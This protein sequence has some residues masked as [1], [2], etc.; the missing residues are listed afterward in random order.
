VVKNVHGG[1]IYT[2]GILKGKALLDFSSNINPLGVPESFRKNIN[3]A[4]N[5][6]DK[7]PDI[8]YR[9][10]I[11][12]LKEYTGKSDS[13]FLLGNG[14]A[15]LLDVS[16]SLTKKLL[17]VVPSFI[18][19]EESAKK[20]GCEI[21]Y[22]YLLPDFTIDYKDI[23]S[24]LEKCDGLVIANPNNPNGACINI[25]E[26]LDILEFGKNNNKIIIVDEAFIEFSGIKEYSLAK[27][28][29]EYPSLIIIRALTKYFSLPGIRFGYAF[30][31][32]KS[33]YE[34]IKQIQLP[35]NINCF[36]EVAV[37]HVL[38]DEKYI[39]DSK[40]WFKEEKNHM[41]SGL[42]DLSIFNKVY[43]SNANY[44]LCELKELNCNEF[45]NLIFEEGMLCRKCDDYIGLSDKF[46]RLAIKDRSSNDKLLKYL[47]NI[48]L[49]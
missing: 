48:D 2:E 33:I 11:E 20:W 3:E 27:Y 36:A 16:I 32:N 35:W 42:K 12:Y 34:R 17:L 46:I 28:I 23:K 9:K 10:T 45:Y 41:I 4:I 8:K 13:Y 24:K 47:K 6:L 7:Y 19:Y 29:N 14:A 49:R 44:I 39:E 26:F 40:K 21:E 1:D 38:F 37:K 22:S 25:K 31:S 18:E 43:P 15:E 5:N 30:T